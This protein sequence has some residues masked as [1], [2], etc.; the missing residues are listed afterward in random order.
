MYQGALSEILENTK[1]DFFLKTISLLRE[2]VDTCYDM[3][4]G[5]PYITCPMKP[6]GSMFIMVRA[7]HTIYMFLFPSEK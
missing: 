6:E 7:S 1:K 5:N 2:A 3:I 4:Q